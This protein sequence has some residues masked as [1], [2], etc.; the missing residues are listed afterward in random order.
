MMIWIITGG[1]VAIAVVL[2]TITWIEMSDA[3]RKSD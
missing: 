2:G 1:I 3:E